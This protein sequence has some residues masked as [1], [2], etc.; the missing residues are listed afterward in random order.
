MNKNKNLPL[1]MQR[2]FHRSDYENGQLE[3]VFTNAGH[4]ADSWNYAN[5]IGKSVEF[6]RGMM[7]L[8]RIALGRAVPHADMKGRSCKITISPDF[9][10]VPSFLW[11]EEKGM[12]GGLIFHSHSQ[13]WGIHT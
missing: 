6:E 5:L 10:N 8:L 3:V 2:Q 11:Q 9:Y 4:L 12:I 7:S 13:E 1:K